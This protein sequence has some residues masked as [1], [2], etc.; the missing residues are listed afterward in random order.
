MTVPH[1]GGSVGA[2]DVV[3]QL[4]GSDFPDLGVLC[5]LHIDGTAWACGLMR[6]NTDAQIQ[7]GRG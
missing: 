1:T 2:S 5:V 7:K 4:I 3:V 6:C